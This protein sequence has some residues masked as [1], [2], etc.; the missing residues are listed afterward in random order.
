LEAARDHFTE[1]VDHFR[2]EQRAEHVPRF[3]H[4]PQVVCASRLANTLWFL[5][6][7]DSARVTRDRALELARRSSHSFSTN[8]VHVFAALLSID[9]GEHDDF[10]TYAAH[11]REGRHQSWVFDVNAKAM[12]GYC[13]VL[14]GRVEEGIAEIRGAIDLLGNPNPVPGARSTFIRMLLGAY[15]VAGDADAGLAAADDALRMDGTT[16]WEPELLRLRAEFLAARGG[17]PGAVADELAR[18]AAVARRRGMLGPTRRIE[19]SRER[20]LH[21]V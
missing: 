17:P 19:L 11:V 20:L 10:R 9:L 1:V 21:T 7:L 13:E 12:T 4:D 2:A 14:D 6:D 5:G 3:G 18:A 8:V 16:L 15:E